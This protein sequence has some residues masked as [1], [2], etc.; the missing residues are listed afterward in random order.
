MPIT[1]AREVRFQEEQRQHSLE[2]NRA[3]QAGRST[4]VF[5]E[6]TAMSYDRAYQ[7]MFPPMRIEP[8]RAGVIASRGDGAEFT[9][10]EA[11]TESVISYS[12][13]YGRRLSAERI[14]TVG[15]STWYEDF[16][17]MK[18]TK[19]ARV[20]RFKSRPE[21]DNDIARP[22]VNDYDLEEEL[23]RGKRKLLKLLA[24]KQF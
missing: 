19:V 10:G 5:E 14:N 2:V 15:W 18:T 23:A 6:M 24:N 9:V 22:V 13:S 21:L 8:R 20:L 3:R 4:D 1:S 17:Q 12:N 7:S 11:P 16:S